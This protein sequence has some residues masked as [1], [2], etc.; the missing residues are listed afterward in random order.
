MI[1]YSVAWRLASRLAKFGWLLAVG[2]ICTVAIFGSYIFVTLQALWWPFL[3]RA[4]MLTP[5][6]VAV[7]SGYGALLAY[8]VKGLAKSVIAKDIGAILADGVL[9]VLFV[10]ALYVLRTSILTFYS[11]SSFIPLLSED[12]L[13]WEARVISTFAIV[14]PI[15]FL[16][17]TTV[18]L[19]LILALRDIAEAF[20][21]WVKEIPPKMA[22]TA[23]APS[24]DTKTGVSHS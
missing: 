10:S 11:A 2:L 24:V 12:I 22:E 19:V 17:T 23:R 3:G 20:L 9:L 4:D 14:L 16:L 13:P 6:K 15:F 1:L 18:C 21:K 5:I 8:V 7:I